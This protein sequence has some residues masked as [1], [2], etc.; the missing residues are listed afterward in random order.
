[1]T[2]LNNELIVSLILLTLLII[3]I[4]YIIYYFKENLVDYFTNTSYKSK[5]K[6]RNENFESNVYNKKI[7]PYDNSIREII[8][9]ILNSIN[10]K[11]NTNY[12]L[13]EIDSIKYEEINNKYITRIFTYE[14]QLDKGYTML[15]TFTADKMNDK[16]SDKININI[17][18]IEV[19]NAIFLP[20]T[21]W[22]NIN[23]NNKK[24]KNLNNINVTGLYQTNIDFHPY[25]EEGKKVYNITDYGRT[26]NPNGYSDDNIKVKN[27]Y[28]VNSEGIMPY[29]NPTVARKKLSYEHPMSYIFRPNDFDG[30]DGNVA[31]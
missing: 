18:S 5:N 10:Q 24:I 15:L 12:N 7:I 19:N 22:T 30:A 16:I 11:Y 25:K 21:I 9:T 31:Y 20:K 4:S 28:A 14:R 8:N 1:M 27:K 26:Y 3:I 13:I 2:I 17:E 29:D 23:T 6:L